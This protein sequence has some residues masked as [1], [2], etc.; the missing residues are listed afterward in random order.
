MNRK[1]K[2]AAKYIDEHTCLPS[3][4]LEG[5]VHIEMCG[6]GEIMIDGRCSVIDL[7]DNFIVLNTSSGVLSIYGVRLQIVTLDPGE[8]VIR[9]EISGIRFG[10][11]AAK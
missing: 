4:T 9:G 11:E 7:N 6:R 3:G 10:E 1:A 5:G 8:A 2:R